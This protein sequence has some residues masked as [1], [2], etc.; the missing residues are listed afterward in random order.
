MADLPLNRQPLSTLAEVVAIA[1]DII[2]YTAPVPDAVLGIGGIYLSRWAD[3]SAY[4]ELRL[5]SLSDVASAAGGVVMQ[6]SLDGI[7]PAP[8]IPAAITAAALAG[9]IYDSGVIVRAY[10]YARI[11]YTNGAAVQAAFR[12][13]LEG[14]PGFAGGGGGGAIVVNVD[15]QG[16]VESLAAPDPSSIR[17]ALADLALLEEPDHALRTRARVLTDEGS[18]AGNFPG[19][20]LY[21]ALTGGANITMT[22]ASTAVTGVGTLF[23]TEIR[24]GDYIE[25]TA[26]HSD[27]VPVLA[28]VQSI[29]SDLALTLRTAWAGATAT[30]AAQVCDWY[31]FRTAV[32][33][34]AIA[35]AAL[36]ATLTITNVN[37]ER[38]LLA[39]RLGPGGRKGCPPI[40][41]GFGVSLNA[42]QGNNQTAIIGL[43]GNLGAMAAIVQ[44]DLFSFTGVANTETQAASARNAP[45][46]MITAQTVTLP[47]G[48]TTTVHVYEV[49]QVGED[50]VNFYIDGRWVFTSP[51]FIPDPYVEM[52]LVMQIENTGVP[53]GGATLS[54]YQARDKSLNVLDTRPV[55]AEADKLRACT[56]DITGFVSGTPRAPTNIADNLVHELTDAAGAGMAPDRHYVV[57]QIGGADLCVYVAAAAPA[58]AVCRYGFHLFNGIPWEFIP[59]QDGLRI[60]GVKAVDGTADMDVSVLATDRGLGA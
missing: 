24:V 32:G 3:V 58:V 8:G 42:R 19:A 11:G 47:I 40:R 28:Q 31:V 27:T 52:Y 43:V 60:W 23:T 35:V 20:S 29:E 17:G 21:R 46:T 51:G 6:W 38:C 16:Q 25:I 44:A 7:I 45:L 13:A 33:G 37:G 22:A 53:V 10:N 54:V 26:Q 4:P 56:R 5:R 14:Y 59:S 57:Q 39:R 12:F 34:E 9:V 48:N 2:R 18:F 36:A 50:I 15:L 49:E 30:A 41:T 55:Q 1:G